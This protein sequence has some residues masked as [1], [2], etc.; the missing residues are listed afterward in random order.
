MLFLRFNKASFQKIEQHEVVK[1]LFIYASH[2]PLRAK[3]QNNERNYLNRICKAI[4]IFESIH[5]TQQQFFL[6]PVL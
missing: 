4:R 2:K 6:K 5:Q 3:L 1:G